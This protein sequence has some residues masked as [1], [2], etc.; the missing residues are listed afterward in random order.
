MSD[1]RWQDMRPMYDFLVK[2]NNALRARVKEL[3]KAL[4]LID[5]PGRQGLDGDR[6]AFAMNE[7]IQIAR[8]AHVD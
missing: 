5:V 4:R 6:L 1:E 8:T 3:E 7:A 2:D